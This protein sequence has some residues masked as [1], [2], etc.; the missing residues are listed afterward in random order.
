[1]SATDTWISQIL[2]I[3]CQNNSLWDRCCCPDPAKGVPVDSLLTQLES[4]YPGNAW[5]SNLLDSVLL[6]ARRIGVVKQV[7]GAWFVFTDF[8]SVN[9]SNARFAKYCPNKI[10]STPCRYSCTP[11]GCNPA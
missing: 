5:T 3:L 1:M 11:N 4:A 9:P 10:C 6:V 8:I 7:A 2:T